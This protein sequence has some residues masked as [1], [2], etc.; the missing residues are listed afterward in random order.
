[1]AWSRTNHVETVGHK[2]LMGDATPQAILKRPRSGN[3]QNCK[4]CFSKLQGVRNL[5]DVILKILQ[6]I[7][8]KRAPQFRK[9]YARVCSFAPGGPGG[10]STFSTRRRIARVETTTPMRSFAFAAPRPSVDPAAHSKPQALWRAVL[11]EVGSLA[12]AFYVM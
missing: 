9:L 11:Q 3:C 5:C 8:K 2:I 1:M 12:I 4:C 6:M 10:D 7:M